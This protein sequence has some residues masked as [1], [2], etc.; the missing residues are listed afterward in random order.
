MISVMSD[1]YKVS[2]ILNTKNHIT[3]NKLLCITALLI[4][5][6]QRLRKMRNHYE[7]SVSD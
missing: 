2:N 7:V 5:L 6:G 3:L 1:D 4:S